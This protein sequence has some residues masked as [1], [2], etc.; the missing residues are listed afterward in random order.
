VF[1]IHKPREQKIYVIPEQSYADG[2]EESLKRY[3]HSLLS[4]LK[5]LEIGLILKVRK[6]EAKE[7]P[8]PR[9]LSAFMFS[10]SPLFAMSSVVY[11]LSEWDDSDIS[12]VCR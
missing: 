10:K 7:C 3:D 8:H 5:A 11:Q 2:G 6:N 12:I 4:G 9:S 1:N